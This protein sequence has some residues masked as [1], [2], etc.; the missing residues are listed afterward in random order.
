MRER[1][2]RREQM[3][4]LRTVDAKFRL[5]VEQGLEHA[6]NLADRLTDRNL[7]AQFPTQIRRGG[8]VIGM[9][10]GFQQPLHLQLMLANEGD[11]LVGLGGGGSPGGGV[12]VEHRVDDRA[13]TAIV[14]RRSRSCRSTRQG[15]EK[16]QSRRAWWPFLSGQAIEGSFIF[17]ALTSPHQFN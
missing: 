14:L 4:E 8:Q 12:V 3:I 11:D 9:G 13:V 1:F 16:L 6:L 17:P 7:A 10:V 2:V 5:K 15:R